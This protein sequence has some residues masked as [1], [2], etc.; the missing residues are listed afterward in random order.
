MQLNLDTKAKEIIAANSKILKVPEDFESMLNDLKV[1]GRREYQN[2]LRI[3]HKYQN[4]VRN[5]KQAQEKKQKEE[6]KVEEP[7]D[8]DAELDK[9]L[10]ATL[11]RI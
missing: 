5:G 9:Q 3:H 11:Q 10:E 4:I 6:A 8:A 2:L 1:C 7:V